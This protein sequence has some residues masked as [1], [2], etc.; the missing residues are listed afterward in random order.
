VIEELLPTAVIAVE[1]RDDLMQ[2]DLFPEEK[3]TVSNAV[4]K[5]RRE[6]ATARGCA[7]SALAQLGFPSLAIPTG[8]HGEA[9]WPQGVVGSITHCAGYRACA[10]ARSRDIGM[11]G[12]DAEPNLPLPYRL[13][14]DI[15]RSEELGQLYGVDAWPSVHRGRLLFSAKEAIYKGWFPLARRRLGFEDAVIMFDPWARTFA[16][17]LLIAESQLPHGIAREL[18]GRW[19]VRDGIIMTAIAC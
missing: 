2:V 4:Q 6:F 13:L 12:I 14:G 18:E 19:M 16:A 1:A 5:R 8:E 15:G 3:S 10:V 7:R 9:I 17:R 11:L